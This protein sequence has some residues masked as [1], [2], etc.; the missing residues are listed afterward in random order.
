MPPAPDLLPSSWRLVKTSL[1]PSILV[2]GEGPNVPLHGHAGLV[3]HHEEELVSL[4]LL[5][6]DRPVAAMALVAV[7]RAVG[8]ELDVVNVPER[9]G[10]WGD[11][12]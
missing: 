7:R 10:E 4:V 5:V 3:V 12:W 8:D 2:T 9:F 11:G 1:L 6:P